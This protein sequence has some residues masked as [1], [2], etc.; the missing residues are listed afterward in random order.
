MGS[1]RRLSPQQRHTSDPQV[2]GDRAAILSMYHRIPEG[3]LV[4][5]ALV[6]RVLNPECIYDKGLVLQSGIHSLRKQ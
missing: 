3:A 6:D 1:Y 4:P 5:R 2:D